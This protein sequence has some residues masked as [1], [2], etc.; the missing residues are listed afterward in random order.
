MKRKGQYCIRSYLKLITEV[1]T[2]ASSKC[3]FLRLLQPQMMPPRGRSVVK[4][5]FTDLDVPFQLFG[6]GRYALKYFIAFVLFQAK[7]SFT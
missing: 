4:P 6:L 3:I 1:G 5:L 2:A 7:R